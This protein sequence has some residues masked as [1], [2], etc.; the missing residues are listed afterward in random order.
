MYLFVPGKK[1]VITTKKLMVIMEFKLKNQYIMFGDSK[2]KVLK[3]LQAPQ[4]Q[5]AFCYK[6]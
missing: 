5:K 1:E 4:I 6:W 2:K 3:S